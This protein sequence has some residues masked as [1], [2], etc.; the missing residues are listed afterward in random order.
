MPTHMREP[1][2]QHT[3]NQT[4]VVRGA[5]HVLRLSA[6]AEEQSSSSSS[7][8]VISATTASGLRSSAPATEDD[9]LLLA[10]TPSHHT[11]N[12]LLADGDDNHDNDDFVLDLAFPAT[13]I[14]F[15]APAGGET[16]APAKS[17][18]ADWFLAPETWAISHYGASTSTY[19]AAPGKAA[20]NNN[21]FIH[22]RLYSANFPVCVQVAYATLA[23]YMHR[24]PVNTGT[25][26]QIIED[27]SNDLLQSNGAVMSMAAGGGGDEEWTADGGG[28]DQNV[29]LYAQLTRLHALMA[30]QIM[31]LFDGDIRSRHVAQ[32]HMAVLDT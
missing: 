22:A 28:A 7:F 12:L 17:N 11:A 19:V 23:S 18:R 15:T 14:D 26:L 25:V 5:A 24:T 21:P 27:R 29:D 6:V 10:E 3:R 8:L 30:Y 20:M 1:C 31:G 2:Q 16:S 4:L 9:G 32:G 13:D